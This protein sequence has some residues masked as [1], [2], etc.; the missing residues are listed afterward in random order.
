MESKRDKG[1]TIILD[2]DS[3]MDRRDKLVSIKFVQNARSIFFAEFDG[4]SL[5]AVHAGIYLFFGV[6]EKSVH[7]IYFTRYYWNTWKSKIKGISEKEFAGCASFVWLVLRE[8]QRIELKLQDK[9][10]L[11]R[12][13]PF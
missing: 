2:G 10:S 1:I 9:Q 13:P 12:K 4:V 5:I 11:E 8:A 3:N 6:P 7:S